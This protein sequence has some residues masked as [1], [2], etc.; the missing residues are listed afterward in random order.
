M[1]LRT[2]RK[3]YEFKFGLKG[4]IIMRENADLVM[5]KDMR[6]ILYCGLISSHSAITFEEIDEIMQECDISKIDIT[7]P[8][9][10]S[11]YEIEEL[12]TKAVG[13]I[14]IAPTDFYSMSPDEI[15]LAYEGYLRRK[16]TEANL[17]K[18]AVISS[19]DESLI[20]LTED[21]GYSIGN[22][23]E[24]DEVFKLLKIID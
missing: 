14:G 15:T 6:F 2:H 8:H 17:I 12:Y 13:E 7:T 11:I 19:D 16:E 3:I 20:R 22:Q 9:L 4:L 10:L 18:L 24:R 1:F 5:A 21:K 23:A